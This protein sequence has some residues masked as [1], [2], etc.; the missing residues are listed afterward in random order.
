M[1]IGKEGPIAISS[2]LGWLLSGPIESTAVANLVSSHMIVT[3]GI[4]NND[5]PLNN[6]QLT[7]ALKHFWETE[8]LGTDY[9]EPEVL[10]N[11]FLKSIEFIDGHYQMPLPWKRDV[12][13]IPDHFL[14]SFNHLKLLQGCL[15][16][17]AELLREYDNVI[18]DQ[19]TKGIIESV[20][21]SVLDVAKDSCNPIHYLP[22][23]AV[24]R[25]DRQTTKIQVVYDGSAKE[26]GQ[27]FSIDDCLHTGPNY[28]PLLFDILIRF[29]SHSIAVAADIEKAFL[30]VHIAEKDRDSLRFLWLHDPFDCHSETLHFHFTRLVF[31]L[32]PTPAI[33][34]A[35]IT[36]HLEKYKFK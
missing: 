11:E 15:L 10:E 30:M 5:T 3:Q 12:V 27:S 1:K 28:I 2:H 17:R 4:D 13:D 23:H 33:L 22:H 8:N 20:N 36:H 25:Q 16:K 24:V 6:D 32:R 31:G 26:K 29:R 7:V 21:P 9:A 14:L 35:V 19:L 34:G 18:K